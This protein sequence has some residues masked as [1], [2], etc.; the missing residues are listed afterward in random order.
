MKTQRSEN[1]TY[2]NL[3]VDSVGELKFVAFC[4]GWPNDRRHMR[5]IAE[6]LRAQG[7]AVEEDLWDQIRPRPDLVEQE[8]RADYPD[9]DQETIASY[10]RLETEPLVIGE[11]RSAWIDSAVLYATDRLVEIIRQRVFNPDPSLHI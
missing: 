10:Q 9:V 6:V 5:V 1:T 2:D 8:L 11:A 3:T 7:V 4:V